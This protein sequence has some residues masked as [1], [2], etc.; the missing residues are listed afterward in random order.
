MNEGRT[1]MTS[2]SHEPERSTR[3]LP[4]ELAQDRIAGLRAS[5]AS[6]HEVHAARDRGLLDR[7]RDALGRRLIGLGSALAV[8]DGLRRRAYRP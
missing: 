1:A 2:I 4:Y 7:S 8:D 5:A 3:D 6:R